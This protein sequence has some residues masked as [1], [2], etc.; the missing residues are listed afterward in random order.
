MTWWARLAARRACCQNATCGSTSLE[1]ATRKLS[2]RRSVGGAPRRHPRA[3]RARR[4]IN[5]AHQSRAAD[6]PSTSTG[7]QRRYAEAASLLLHDFLE[8]LTGQD[9]D[10]GLQRDVTG[11]PAPTFVAP[12]EVS[13]P[14]LT[15]A[16][17]VPLAGMIA[18]RRARSGTRA[19]VAASHVFAPA[20]VEPAANV[21]LGKHRI[22]N[23]ASR[24][25]RRGC[26][27]S[28][29]KTGQRRQCES[30]EIPP[31]EISSVEIDL[32]RHHDA[33]T[34]PKPTFGFFS[35]SSN[36]RAGHREILPAAP[37]RQI[38]TH[39]CERRS[40]D[41]YPPMAA[42]RKRHWHCL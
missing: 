28:G 21:G 25:I 5:P 41:S 3:Q 12:G 10:S 39:S 7:N 14:S 16:V 22:P 31:R 42:Q 19:M 4:S 1:G 9:P 18:R 17:V 26:R 6:K 27:A 38:L 37:R 11:T 30:C 15:A 33:P 20:G 8:A 34:G 13:T 2:P 35:R 36:R 29:R 40:G 24:H 23:S 32:I